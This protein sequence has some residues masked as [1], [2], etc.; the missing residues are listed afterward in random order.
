[1]MTGAEGRM[2]SLRSSRSIDAKVP[3]GLRFRVGFEWASASFLAPG[4]DDS[5]NAE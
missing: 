2:E 1:M 3:I 4:E 5:N